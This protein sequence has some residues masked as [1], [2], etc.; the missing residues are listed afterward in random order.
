MKMDLPSVANDFVFVYGTLLKGERNHRLLS[1]STF[2]GNG[3][4]KD[5][6]MCTLGTYP[7]VIR[8]KG[9]VVGEVY[10]VSEETLFELDYLE[11]EGLLYKKEYT[12]VLLSNGTIVKSYVYLFVKTEKLIYHDHVGTYVHSWRKEEYVYYVSYG[13]NMLYDRFKLYL[14]GGEN[15]ELMI[16]QVG[17]RDSSVPL[18]SL[19]YKIEYNMYFANASDK[20]ENMGVSFLDITKPGFAFGRAYLIKKEQLVN[21]HSQEGNSPKWYNSLHKLGELNSLEVFTFT[22]LKSLTRNKPGLKYLEILNKG[23][24]E[25]NP[26]LDESAIKQYFNNCQNQ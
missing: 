23:L 7:G 2:V 21:V 26:D 6:D 15:K 25:I 20:W 22:N 17:A 16:K 14:T 5:F 13:S 3:S 4:I 11:D 19:S 8:G 18:E 9:I 1:N 24:T 12:E 10:A